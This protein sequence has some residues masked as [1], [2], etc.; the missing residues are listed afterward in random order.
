M[1]VDAHAHLDRYGDDLGNALAELER[2]RILTVSVSMDLVSYRRNV[3]IAAACELVLPTFGV[4]P[5][6]A[7]AYAGRLGELREPIRQSPMLGEIGLDHHFVDDASVYPAQ[8]EVF[9]FFLQAAAEQRKIVNLHTSG[10]EEEVL[11]LLKRYDV[12]RAVVHWYSGPLDVF[13]EL[14]AW[15]AYFAVGVEVLH[16]EHIRDIARRVPPE[17][18]LTE[19]DN[20]GGLKWLTRVPGMPSVIK[21]VVAAVA[22]AREVDVDDVAVLARGNFARLIKG[23]PRLGE[24]REKFF[25]QASEGP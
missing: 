25:G 12:R 16:S 4:H 3:E 2:D 5:W 21:E 23:D 22:C 9:E 14:A 20:P 24:T 13:D 18:L 17:R 15:G 1:Y 10:A 7:P 11:A 19:T 6:N 8:R